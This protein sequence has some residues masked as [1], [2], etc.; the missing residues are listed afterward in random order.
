MDLVMDFDVR[1]GF[2]Q[3]VKFAPSLGCVGCSDGFPIARISAVR[4]IN[5]QLTKLAEFFDADGVHP[6]AKLQSR[7]GVL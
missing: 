2:E 5:M 1:A 6:S 7:R 3:A 4:D